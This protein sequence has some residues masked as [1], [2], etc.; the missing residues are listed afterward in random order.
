MVWPVL[1]FLSRPLLVGFTQLIEEKVLSYLP[2]P[3]RTT[4]PGNWNSNWVIYGSW[5]SRKTERLHSEHYIDYSSGHDSWWRQ[6]LACS[7]ATALPLHCARGGRTQ[8]DRASTHRSPQKHF[9]KH[10][11]TDRLS[12]VAIFILP[13]LT[14]TIL[15]AIC[16]LLDRLCLQPKVSNFARV[17]TNWI[18]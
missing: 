3:T 13:L 1:R 14:T 9:W 12:K 5:P 6:L 7:P 17:S 2:S 4:Q 16:F 18:Q 8:T 15:S 10:I 11:G